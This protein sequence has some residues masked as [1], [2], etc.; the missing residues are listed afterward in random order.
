MSKWI[1]TA[2]FP[3]HTDRARVTVKGRDA[4]AL[5]LLVQRGERGCS[6]VSEPT[7]PRWSSYIHRLRRAGFSIVSIHESHKGEFPGRHV[8]YVLRDRV[9][10]ARM[11]AR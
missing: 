6:P 1:Y 10:L 9:E 8:R 7:G 5:R 11:E 4:W 3:G 2:S